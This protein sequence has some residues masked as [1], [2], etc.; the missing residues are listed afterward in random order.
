MAN[1]SMLQASITESIRVEIGSLVVRGW[2]PTL[3]GNAE[4]LIDGKILPVKSIKI[5]GSIPNPWM[6]TIEYDPQAEVHRHG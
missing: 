4:I 6:V 5:E 2:G 3:A 1:P